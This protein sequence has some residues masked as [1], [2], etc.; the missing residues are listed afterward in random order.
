[1]W[2]NADHL[3]C[4]LRDGTVARDAATRTRIE[5]HLRFAVEA[6]RAETG[7]YPTTLDT[8]LEIG[9]VNPGILGRAAD[10]DLRYKLTRDGTGY[11]LL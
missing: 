2:R 1:V 4:V 8:L 7:S 10:L 5:H 9:Y 11:T 3:E 6:F